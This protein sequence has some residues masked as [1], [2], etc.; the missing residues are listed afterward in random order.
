[1]TFYIQAVWKMNAASPVV[2]KVSKKVMQPVFSDDSES[3]ASIFKSGR[4]RRASPQVSINGM[5]ILTFPL[6]EVR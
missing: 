3:W 1:M 4:K 6:L 2:Q 5:L